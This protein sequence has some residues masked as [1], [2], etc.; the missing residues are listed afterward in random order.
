MVMTIIP[1]AVAAYPSFER[2][3]GYLQPAGLGNRMLNFIPR[4][5]D[6]QFAILIKDLHVSW[7][8]GQKALGGVSL[9]V[10]KGTIVACSGP[11]G[12]GKT[13]LAR[14]ILGEAFPTLS[15]V[16]KVSANRLAYCAQ[17]SWLPNRTIREVI[18]G[19][20]TEYPGDEAWYRAVINACCLDQDFAILPDG[21]GTLVGD[22]GMNLSGGQRQRVALARAVF[23]RC[24]VAVLDDVFSALDGRTEKNVAENLF[25]AEGLFRKL[26]TTVF[27]ITS[28]TQHFHLA[29]YA[30]VLDAGSVQE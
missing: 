23:Q 10:S 27:W 20:G 4:S 22:G 28:S 5:H 19:P 13:T 21:D 11:V 24:E 2:I 30:V 8:S 16:V 14:V 9:G 17:T 1:K 18:H 26:G 7:K 25:G 12:S 3:Q 29:D 15:G 6:L